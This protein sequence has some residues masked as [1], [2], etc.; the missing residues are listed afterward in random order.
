MSDEVISIQEVIAYSLDGSYRVSSRSKRGSRVP[1]PTTARK[2]SS[3]S[4]VFRDQHPVAKPCE[5]PPRGTLAP[6][7]CES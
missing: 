1:S 7:I 2:P 4:F 5:L 6:P 3:G